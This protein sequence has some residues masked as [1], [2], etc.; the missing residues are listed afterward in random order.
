MFSKKRS[1]SSLHKIDFTNSLWGASMFS[2]KSQRHS[3]LCL[4]SVT[5]YSDVSHDIQ[6]RLT[7]GPIEYGHGVRDVLWEERVE[8]REGAHHEL[9]IVQPI[10]IT[11]DE[12]VLLSSKHTCGARGLACTVGGDQLSVDIQVKPG[13]PFPCGND[14]HPLVD[15]Q[16]RLY[17]DRQTLV[18]IRPKPTTINPIN[19]GD[20]AE[21]KEIPKWVKYLPFFCWRHQ[22]NKHLATDCIHG[23]PTCC[24]T[25]GAAVN[26]VSRSSIT[27]RFGRKFDLCSQWESAGTFIRVGQT[28]CRFEVTFESRGDAVEL[29]SSFHHVGCSRHQQS[30]R[31]D[32]FAVSY[33]C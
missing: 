5:W 11:A 13:V 23:H 9:C 3:V 2:K 28:F 29:E 19:R 22:F 17:L 27:S 20:Y 15:C 7:I 30:R 26:N 14:V 12:E 6:R 33:R 31:S 32:D 25:A 24:P 10:G 1:Q 21:T 4:L 16:W 18:K 8:R